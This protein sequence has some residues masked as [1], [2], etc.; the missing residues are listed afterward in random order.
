MSVIELREEA[1]RDRERKE[2]M[3]LRD[4]F[5]M[6]ALTGII[7]SGVRGGHVSPVASATTAYAVAD[8]MVEARVL[9]AKDEK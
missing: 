1:I 9:K 2:A 7:A 8:A 6:A 5:A 4:E 3:R